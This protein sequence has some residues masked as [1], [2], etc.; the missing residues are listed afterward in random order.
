MTIALSQLP[1]FFRDLERRGAVILS[2]AVMTDAR[3]RKA[4]PYPDAKKLVLVNGVYN[5]RYSNALA[6]V[7]DAP[8]QPRAW[9]TRISG[10]LV[11]H[12]GRFYVSIHVRRAITSPIYYARNGDLLTQIDAAELAP[13]LPAPKAEVVKVRDYALDSLVAIKLDGQRFKVTAR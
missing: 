2:L 4:C 12:K 1:Q 5:Y 7:S 6:K 10:G 13:F 11:E 3:A 9:G 8:V